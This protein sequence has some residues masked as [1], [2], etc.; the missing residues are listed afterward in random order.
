MSTYN[1]ME[2]FRASL[3]VVRLRHPSGGGPGCWGGGVTGEGREK[4]ITKLFV[5]YSSKNH[6]DIIRKMVVVASLWTWVN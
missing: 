6:D 5:V 1:I 2:G 4:N 3:R